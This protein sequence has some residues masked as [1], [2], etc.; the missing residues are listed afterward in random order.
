MTLVSLKEAAT[1]RECRLAIGKDY[2]HSTFI[3]I[4]INGLIG[5]RTSLV[6]LLQLVVSPLAD[7]NAFTWFALDNVLYHG[8]NISVL[9]DPT[10]TRWNAACDGFCVFVDGKLANRTATMQRV[11]VGLAGDWRMP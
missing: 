7:T 6:N 10:G 2:N 9:Y 1:E 11:V 5:L 3:D 4:I 8:R